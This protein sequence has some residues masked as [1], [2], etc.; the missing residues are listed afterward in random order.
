[1]KLDVAWHVISVLSHAVSTWKTSLP[2]AE[3]I[4]AQENMWI[5]NIVKWSSLLWQC[6]CQRDPLVCCIGMLFISVLLLEESLVQDAE[7]M[8][9]NKQ[10]MIFVCLIE[11]WYFSSSWQMSI[12]N[13]IGMSTTRSWRDA[14][15]NMLAYLITSKNKLISIFNPSLL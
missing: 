4:A 15:K 5:I 2:K 8:D 13:Y 3:Q 6:L 1:V 14:Q 12:W 7:Y 10:C 11:R 9:L